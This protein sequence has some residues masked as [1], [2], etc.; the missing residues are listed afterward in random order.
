MMLSEVV[1]PIGGAGVPVDVKVA[2]ADFVADPKETHIH[3][4][5]TFLF[6]GIVGNTGSKGNFNKTM[7]S[8]Y[9]NMFGRSEPK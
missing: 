1:G 7:T 4:F 2:L 6:H 9:S 3:G 5:G 8:P